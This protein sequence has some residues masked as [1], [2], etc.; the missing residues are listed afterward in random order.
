MENQYHKQA[1]NF[2]KKHGISFSY[3]RQGEED[4]QICKGKKNYVFRFTFSRPGKRDFSEIFHGSVADYEAHKNAGKDKQGFFSFKQAKKDKERAILH[5]YDVIAC[6]TK[7]SP[8]T[9]ADWCNE[10]GYDTDS[11]KAFSIYEKVC[12]EWGEVRA[13]FTAE[14]RE[15]MQ[16]IN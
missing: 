6:L 5:A 10:F 11:R 8:E 2:L 9:F 7:Y 4:S 14:E 1:E 13:F 16:E 15:E 3:V 12:E